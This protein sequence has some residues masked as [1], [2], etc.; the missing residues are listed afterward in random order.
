MP[1]VNN[2]GRF[3]R[4]ECH[5]NSG[6]WRWWRAFRAPRPARILTPR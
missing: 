4:S 6:T 1:T 3:F 5:P 2:R